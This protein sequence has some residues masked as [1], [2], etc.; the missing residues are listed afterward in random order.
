MKAIVWNDETMGAEYEVQEI[1]ENLK[2]KA[3]AFHAQLVETVAENDDDIL[4]K[5]LEGEEITAARVEN[6]SAEI[7]N[8]PEGIS[9]SCRNVVQE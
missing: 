1:P 8:R 7:D 6:V 5:F 4:H 9:G 2:K 3:E